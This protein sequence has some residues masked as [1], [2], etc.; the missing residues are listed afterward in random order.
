MTEMELLQSIQTK[1][2]A[3]GVAQAGEIKELK[4]LIEAQKKADEEIKA[5]V[6]KLNVEAGKKDATLLDIQNEVKELKAKGG[7]PKLISVGS[8]TSIPNILEG[9][10]ASIE[11]HKAAIGTGALKDPVEVK[12]VDIATASL[13]GTN[14]P[15]RSYL[16]WQPGMEPTGQTRF[17][18]FVKTLQSATDSVSFPRANSPVGA[19]SFGRQTEAAT[20]AQ[21]DRGYAMI[22]VS[23]KP[24]AGFA[25]ASRQSLRNII[26]LQSWLPTSMME[27]LQDNE[28]IDFI[29]TL[30]S[31]AT[32][33]STAAGIT[34]NAEKLIYYMKNLMVAKYN[35]TAVAID[36]TPWAS[37]LVTKPND[38]SIPNS[39]VIDTLGNV[40]ILGRPLTPV[41]WLTGG[42]V[43]VGDW[44]RAAIVQSEGLTMRQSDSHASIFATNEIA[45]LL[46]RTEN[47]AVFRPDAFITALL[48]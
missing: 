37:I 30:V 18:S 19:G 5:E 46:E 42:R 28:D 21:V 15:Y 39:V 20:K 12:A 44:S 3:S 16:D 34:V 14:A 2:E 9:I 41:N 26:F 6:V 7:R 1:M 45:F 22:D 10:S 8:A 4:G 13:T 38:Y 17:R 36:P 31:A 29:N 43:V 24:M 23:L 33:S 47:L 40:R 27:Q 11:E 35:P 25:I 48:T 32:G